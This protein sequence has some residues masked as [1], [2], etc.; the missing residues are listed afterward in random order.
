M[1]LTASVFLTVMCLGWVCWLGRFGFDFTDESFYLIWISN[2]FE[3][4]T[5]VT[6]FGFVYH[7]LFKLVGE[8][9]VALRQAN[10][11][12]SWSLSLAVCSSFLSVAFPRPPMERVDRLVISAALATAVLSSVVF[13]DYWLATPSYNTLTMQALLVAA[14]G[15]LLVNQP[16]ARTIRFGW[17]LIGVGGGLAFLAKPPAA[18]ALAVFA[19]IYL[20]AVGRLSIKLLLMALSIAGGLLLVFGLLVD[21]SVAGF[22]HRLVGGPETASIVGGG[23]SAPSLLRID[24]F[25]PEGKFVGLLIFA[26]TLF[27][28]AG[29]FA[30]TQSRRMASVGRALSICFALMT[31]VI[32]AD[33]FP[34]VQ[35]YGPFPGLLLC[36]VP[37]SAAVLLVACRG[38]D[39]WR[40]LSR[41]EWALFIF[42]LSLPYAYSTGTTN[43]QWTLMP[44]VAVFWLLAGLVLLRPLMTG[45]GAAVMV[46]PLEIGRAHV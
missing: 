16:A 31:F 35:G 42:F 39:G 9:I 15:V 5:S 12:I 23:R 20:Y 38:W 24:F 43:N 41:P 1:L 7:L 19:G 4:S 13:S 36:S 46:L 21:G 45:A 37:L 10:I 8:D 33:F 44:Q 25:R 26:T 18:V 22:I 28:A 6:Q 14:W 29:F 34:G 11:L 3:Y 17:I 27:F 40:Q 30:R 32:V 2:P